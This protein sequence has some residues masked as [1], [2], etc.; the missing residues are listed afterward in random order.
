MHEAALFRAAQPVPTVVLGMLLRPLSLGHILFYV[1]SGITDD[2]AA[3]KLTAQKLTEAVMFGSQ[4]WDESAGLLSDHLLGLK[5]WIWR[6]RVE[7]AARRHE[8]LRRR[9]SDLRPYFEVEA[10]KFAGWLQ[11]G[12]EELPVS[13][14][15]RADKGSPARLPGSPF[16]LR[17]Q[18]WLMTTLRLTES[19]AW[20]YPFGLAKMRWACHWESEGGIDIRNEN[21]ESFDRF[22]REQEAK[23]SS[24]LMPARN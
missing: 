18:Q 22:V 13:D 24:G 19:Q 12:C 5:L 4:S 11:A 1:Q 7:R 8:K 9:H 20:N 6:K 2:I 15:P 10:A 16:L 3:G 14:T 21:D 23:R 17:I